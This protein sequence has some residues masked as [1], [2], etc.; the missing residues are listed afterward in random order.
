MRDY[1]QILVSVLFSEQVASSGWPFVFVVPTL[2]THLG[3]NIN[4]DDFLPSILLLL[5][6]IVAV[7]IVVTVIPVVVVVGE[8]SSIIKLPFVIIVLGTFATRKYRFSSFKPADEANNAFRTFE[9]ERLA[10]HKLFVATFSCYRISTLSGVPIGISV[11][12]MVATCAF[13]AVT[14]LSATSFLMAA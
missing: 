5:V 2:M 9:I 10:A 6:I 14:T 13:R 1:I 12:A 7:A 3:D 4:P 11:F 8:G